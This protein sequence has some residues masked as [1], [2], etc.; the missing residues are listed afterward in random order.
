MSK[1]LTYVYI[2]LVLAIFL[3]SAW[4]YPQLPDVVAT[5]WGLSGEPN[6]FSSAFFGA[7]F[8][9]VFILGL[10]L[11]FYFLP[12]IDP[13]K[14]NWEEFH[15]SY[16]IFVI[17]FVAVMGY[18]HGMTLV[19]NLGYAV[20]MSMI[21]FPAMAV[22]FMTLGLLMP[23]IKQNWFMGIRTPWTI[24][25]TTVWDK[26]H[27]LGGKLFLLAGLSAFVG[28]IYPEVGI[29]IFLSVVLIAA[30][31]PLIYSYVL[32]KKQNETGSI[33]SND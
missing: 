11:L 26:T 12:K 29:Y 5:H 8:M 1:R 14:K 32:F 2:G 27:Q 9:P 31:V 18:I 19:Y 24:S 25:D 6:G 4:A 28:V 15:S 33:K 16:E 23:N 22:L 17:V 30:I 10:A 21:L 13:L 7:F 20:N 3:V